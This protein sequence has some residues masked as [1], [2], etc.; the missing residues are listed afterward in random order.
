MVLRELSRL[1]Q[2]SGRMA[3]FSSFLMQKKPSFVPD[4]ESFNSN[5]GDGFLVPEF[6][7]ESGA[8]KDEQADSSNRAAWIWRH[9]CPLPARLGGGKGSPELPKNIRYAM[10]CV[11]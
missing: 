8:S 1:G 3:S 9:N 7:D 2:V 11:I 6:K 4:S 10:P 5:I